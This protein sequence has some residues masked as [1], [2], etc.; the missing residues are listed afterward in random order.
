MLLSLVSVTGA[1]EVP[2]SALQILGGQS[3]PRPQKQPVTHGASVDLK[4]R[5]IIAEAG[6]KPIHVRSYGVGPLDARLGK[7]DCRIKSDGPPDAQAKG[8][9]HGKHT[10]G[11]DIKVHGS[12]ALFFNGLLVQEKT[13][14]LQLGLKAPSPCGE[15]MS[16]P[17]AEAGIVGPVSGVG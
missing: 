3:Q 16:K 10:V 13:R 15:D 7:Q 17:Q 12:G 11:R 1:V 4:S 9:V 5:S 6:L 14:Q 8:R 2:Q